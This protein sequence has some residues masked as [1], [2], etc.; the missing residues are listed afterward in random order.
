MLTVGRCAGLCER[1][2][3]ILINTSTGDYRFCCNGVT[4]TGRGKIAKQGNTYSMEHNPIDRR[5]RAS[6]TG[7]AHSG[8]ASLQS[9]GGTPKCN[10]TDSDTTNNTTCGSCQ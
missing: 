2:H 10:I 3:R 6:I 8:T 9:P 4:Y 7:S 1:L 5:V